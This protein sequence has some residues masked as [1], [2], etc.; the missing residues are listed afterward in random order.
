MVLCTVL[1]TVCIRKYIRFTHLLF[2]DILFL[3]KLFEILC[4]FFELLMTE[5]TYSFLD[6]SNLAL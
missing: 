1:R 3:F 6:P 5:R 4:D 2:F